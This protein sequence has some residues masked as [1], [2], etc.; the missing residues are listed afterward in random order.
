M[1]VGIG[2][3]DTGLSSSHAAANEAATRPHNQFLLRAVSE[4]AG[5]MH[6]C[7]AAARSDTVQSRN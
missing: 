4:R 1:T 2:E 6:S 5:L 3:G 7:S